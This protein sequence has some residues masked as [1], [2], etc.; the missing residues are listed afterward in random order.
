MSHFND[1]PEDLQIAYFNID[2]IRAS[3]YM[4]TARTA[5]WRYED[6]D[7]LYSFTATTAQLRRCTCGQCDLPKITKREL[8]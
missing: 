6:W 2:G 7:Q 1:E 8:S 4:K 3:L 5:A